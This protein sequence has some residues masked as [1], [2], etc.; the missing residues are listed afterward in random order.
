MAAFERSLPM[1]LHRTLSAVMPPFREIFQRHDLTDQQWRVLRA[2]WESGRLSIA[3][4]AS[5][6]VLPAPSLVGIL[7]RLERRGLVA[8]IRSVEDRRLVHVAPTEAG[9][10]LY[11]Q[12]LPEITEIHAR[13]RAR[14]TD[15]EWDQ[16]ERI[17][18]KIASGLA[19]PRAQAGE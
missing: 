18:G 8:R 2:L 16:M 14:V 13:L 19:A 5:V 9:R 3:Q 6:T 1:V 12:V 11:R 10:A 4:L 7:D 17:L 15:A